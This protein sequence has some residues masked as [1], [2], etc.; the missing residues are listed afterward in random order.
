MLPVG[1]PISFG[2]VGIFISPVF[3]LDH[4]VLAKAPLGTRIRRGRLSKPFSGV[5][6][7]DKSSRPTQQ[8]A[9]LMR[10]RAM[11]IDATLCVLSDL[12][13]ISFE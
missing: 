7:A 2:L 6:A 10:P 3:G 5:L 1:I 12:E 13:R 11:P 9:E 4:L 8:I